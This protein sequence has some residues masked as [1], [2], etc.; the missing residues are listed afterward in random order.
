GGIHPRIDVRPV[1]VRDSPPAHG[2]RGVQLGCPGERPDR[3]RVVEAVDQSEALVEVL[4]SSGD[5]GPD[6][7]VVRAEIL[8]ERWRWRGLLGEKARRDQQQN[9]STATNQF[10]SRI[11]TALGWH[12]T[13]R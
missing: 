12:A 3:L 8:V 2:T 10:D 1:R 11:G 9:G 6:R 4:L 13:L 7:F 5:F